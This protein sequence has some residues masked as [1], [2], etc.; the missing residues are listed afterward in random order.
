VKNGR[1]AHPSRLL[2]QKKWQAKRFASTEAGP[3]P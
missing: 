1:I 2:A 3:H